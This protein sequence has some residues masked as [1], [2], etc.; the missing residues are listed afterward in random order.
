ML[1]DFG[2]TQNTK[3]SFTLIYQDNESKISYDP[4]DTSLEDAKFMLLCSCESLVDGE[5]DI[6]D[7]YA[8]EVNV[9]ELTEIKNNSVFY[10]KKK[11]TNK[12]SNLLLDGRRK[13][14]V[15]IEP[16]RHIEAQTA[17]KFMCVGSNLLKHTK[18]GYPH[19]RLFQLSSDLKRILWYTKSKSID[20]AQVNVPSISDITIGQISET[21]YQ[22]PL[23]KLEDLSFSIYYT[24][25]DNQSKTLDITCKDEKEFDLWVIGIKALHSYFNHKIISKQDLLSHSRC[26]NEQVRKGNVGSC[27]K[28]LFYKSNEGI[29]TQNLDSFLTNRDLSTITLIRTLLRLIDRINVIRIEVNEL[30]HIDVTDSNKGQQFSDGGY[31]ALF[32]EEAI[33]DDLDT[34]KGQMLNLFNRC[35]NELNECVD[36][37]L[38][39]N[40]INRY[41]SQIVEP[42][43]EVEYL[44]GVHK[45]EF[46]A[47]SNGSMPAMQLDEN[48]EEDIYTRESFNKE[49]DIKTWKI[50][51][52]MENVGD[53]IKRFRSYNDKGF[54]NKLKEIF[55]GFI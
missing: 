32:D 24:N 3:I 18:K 31:E 29:T 55:K 54:F 22:H 25:K 45:L 8:K 6:L 52:D 23:K 30:K 13:L 51:V 1:L 15:E 48:E 9:N 28:F 37:F 35:E 50:E 53:I 39:W 47:D 10:I 34:Q 40:K 44:D 19:L 49:M 36:E 41:N 46:Y 11:N 27:T 5:F 2:D 14:Y 16:L 17:I 7:S 33:V 42:K 12:V 21:F 20:E 26:Y 43:D 4:S 38:K